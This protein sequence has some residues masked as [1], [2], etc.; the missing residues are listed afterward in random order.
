[1][2]EILR[3]EK[4]LEEFVNK[5]SNKDTL[6]EALV[7]YVNHEK[8]KSKH[9]GVMMAYDKIREKFIEGVSK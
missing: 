7:L 8:F 5:Y 4:D 3:I 6:V 1:M 2:E 9:D